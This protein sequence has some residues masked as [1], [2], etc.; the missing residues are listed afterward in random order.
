MSRR[1]A[2]QQLG[3]FEEGLRRQG[4]KAICGVDEAGRGPLA[5][6]VVAAAV[7]LPEELEIPGLDDSK[8]LTPTQRERVFEQIVVSECP[9]AVGVI[10]H[11]TIDTINI[12]KAAL[13]AMRK[14]VLALGSRPEIVLVDG[15]FPIPKLA[16][17]QYALVGADA[18]C[19]AVAAA[20]ILAKVTRDRIM[21][22]YEKLFP[23]YRFSVH[24][25]YPTPDHLAELEQHGPCEIHRKSFRPVAKLL[26]PTLEV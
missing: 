20:S 3:V 15:N 8:K 25:G 21:N 26:E 1:I 18:S 23:D 13:M 24:K 14:A 2:I 4:Y 7:I 12:L 16:Y 19:K 6:P 22:D 17:P 5:G 11:A 10:D 9:V